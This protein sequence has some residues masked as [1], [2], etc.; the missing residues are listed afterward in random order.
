MEFK[1]TQRKFRSNKSERRKIRN[2][3]GS[4]EKTPLPEADTPVI[5]GRTKVPAHFKVPQRALMCYEAERPKV[6]T[7]GVCSSFKLV[8]HT[9]LFFQ[10]PPSSKALE[11]ETPLKIPI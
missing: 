6:L 9:A 11:V 4:F 2:H 7:L 1:L 10:L 5:L 3:P 8:K